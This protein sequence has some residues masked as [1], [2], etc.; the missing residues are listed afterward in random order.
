MTLDILVPGVILLWGAVLFAA[1]AG[2]ME[3]W[4]RNWRISLRMLMIVAAVIALTLGCTMYTL[5]RF[6]IVAPKPPVSAVQP[7]SPANL[8]RRG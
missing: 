6:T 7:A 4:Q 1:I 8:F 3:L 5:K 2:L